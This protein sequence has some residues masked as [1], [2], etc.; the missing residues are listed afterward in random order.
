MTDTHSRQPELVWYLA[1]GSNMSSAKFTGGRGIVPLDTVRVRIP[2][3]ILAMEIPGLPYSEP[4][5]SSIVPRTCIEAVVEKCATPDLVGLAYLITQDQYRHVLASEGGGTAYRD[6][7][8]RGEALE[9][10][11]SQRIGHPILLRTLATAMRRQPW[12]A[13]SRRYKDLLVQGG[14]EARLPPKYQQYL[15]EMACYNPPD[16]QWTKIG[17]FIF[18]TMWGPVMAF[19]E[20]IT[21]ISIQEDGNALPCV[22]LLV[23]WTMFIIWASHDYLFAPVFGRGDGL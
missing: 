5:F 12:P 3:W 19:L 23:R 6:I 15:S 17:A 18:T 11:D 2:G 16:A 1:Y 21:G 14:E 4:S 8:V 22:I 9:A 20:W 7:S 13:P 10:E